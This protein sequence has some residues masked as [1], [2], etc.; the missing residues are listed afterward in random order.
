MFEDEIADVGVVGEFEYVFAEVVHTL[1]VS[2]VWVI[3]GE[4]F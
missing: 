2:M 4:G 3:E 1:K